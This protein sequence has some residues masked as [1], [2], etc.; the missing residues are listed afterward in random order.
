[1]SKPGEGLKRGQYQL[2][3]GIARN[4]GQ[5]ACATGVMFPNS[6]V[7]GICMV[8]DMLLHW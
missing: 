6:V 5:K 4:L 8:D 1:M 7:Q 2:M 3:A